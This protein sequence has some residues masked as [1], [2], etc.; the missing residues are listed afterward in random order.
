MIDRVRLIPSHLDSHFASR[1]KAMIDGMEL[2]G[3][4]HLLRTYG[5]ALILR[6]YFPVAHKIDFSPLQRLTR[7]ATSAELLLHRPS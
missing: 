3:S 2:A 6:R 5:T 4:G 7:S 1:W